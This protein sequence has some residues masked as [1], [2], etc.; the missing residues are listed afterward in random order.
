MQQ[1]A[2]NT[3]S[4]GGHR[5]TLRRGQGYGQ[6]VTFRP[7]QR[8]VGLVGTLH[9][10]EEI[11]LGAKVDGRVRKIAHDVADR[12]KP[13]EVLLEIDPTDYQLNVRQAQRA[14]QVELAKLGLEDRPSAKS[15]SRGFPPWSRPNCAATTRRRG[16]NG[17]NPG[18]AQGQ[19]RGRSSRRN[20][21][22]PRRPGRIR[23][24][25]ARGQS[26]HR[27]DSGQARGPGHR[28]A[29]ILDSLVRVPEPS[30][31][32]PGL[33]NGSSYAIISRRFP[34][35]ATSKPGPTFSRSSSKAAQV[36]R[37]R[38]RGARAARSAGTKSGSPHGRL[39]ASFPGEVTRINPSIDPQTRTFEVEIL[40][41]NTQ[42]E[43]KPGGFAKTAILTELDEQAATVPL[44][45]L[46]YFAG[47]TK[48]FLVEVA[49][50]RNAS[51]AGHARHAMG[52]DRH[53]QAAAR[54]RKWSPA[55]KPRS[56]TA[57]PFPCAFPARS[58]G[59]ARV[60]PRVRHPIRAGQIRRG[61]HA[62]M[63]RRESAP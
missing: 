17:P 61:R 7:V 1:A 14:L 48:I 28:Q 13:G 58:H 38:A 6:P 60:R 27:G 19:P 29:T 39:F 35:A 33:E 56:P 49:R 45:A 3:A 34:K 41:P 57:R 24:P 20:V 40:V 11:S 52:R 2:G 50:P 15:T 59:A 18:R 42:S 37:P 16:W 21:R 32:V 5:R 54:T 53:A 10:Y 51:D 46:V 9:G 25:G 8:T 47:V 4:G 23:Q 43:L 30:Q 36:P 44:E 55:D 62:P 26:R 12:V 22:V 31:P 63:A